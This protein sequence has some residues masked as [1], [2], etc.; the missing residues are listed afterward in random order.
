MLLKSFRSFEVWQRA[1][2]LITEIHGVTKLLPS[3][4][5]FG[6]SVQMCRAS[7]SAASHIG[8]GAARKSRR[9]FLRALYRA[10]GSLGE[11]F[12][13][14]KVCQ[15]LG[16]LEEKKAAKILSDILRIERTITA[17]TEHL[18]NSEKY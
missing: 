8:Q 10:Q 11:L 7:L 18:K 1:V 15:R 2:D 9:E 6:L 16:F 14:V 3:N 13:Q 12:T 4:E 17:L 5:P